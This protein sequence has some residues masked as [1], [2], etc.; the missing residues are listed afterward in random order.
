[1]L[2]DAMLCY[3]ICMNEG[4]GEVLGYQEGWIEDDEDGK[5]C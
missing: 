3:A 1:M 4:E 5:S 2:C